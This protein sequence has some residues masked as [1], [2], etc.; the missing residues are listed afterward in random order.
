MCC[1]CTERPPT[2]KPANVTPSRRKR[3]LVA[4][5]ASMTT[6]LSSDSYAP[7]LQRH[8]HSVPPAALLDPTRV[9]SVLRRARNENGRIDI[10]AQ[11]R[12]QFDGF[13]RLTLG[14]GILI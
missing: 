1:A 2:A 13:E 5:F 6:H 7:I 9:P 8:P 14:H 10:V 11:F 3:L 12:C 4:R